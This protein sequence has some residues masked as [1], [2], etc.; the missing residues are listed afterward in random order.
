MVDFNAAH[1]KVSSA[2]R[3][4]DFRR[5]LQIEKIACG[6]CGCFL[7]NGAMCSYGCK[8]DTH[9][10][11]GRPLILRRYVLVEEKEHKE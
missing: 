11:D 5:C 10:M 8:Y 1:I 9:D 3:P 2:R 7:M 4:E 6:A